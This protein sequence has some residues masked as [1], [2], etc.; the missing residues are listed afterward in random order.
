M[1]S[2]IQIF[3]NWC[4]DWNKAVLVISWFAAPALWESAQKILWLLENTWIPRYVFDKPGHFSRKDT[5][6]FSISRLKEEV[7]SSIMYLSQQWYEQIGMVS[8]SLS[9]LSVAEAAKSMKDKVTGVIYLAPVFDPKKAIANKVIHTTWI[10]IPQFTNNYWVTDFNISSDFIPL[11][12]WPNVRL[13]KEQFAQ[14]LATYGA[15]PF[16]S[17]KDIIGDA[18]TTIFRHPD[19]KIISPWLIEKLWFDTFNG[20][21]IPDDPFS[22]TI[23]IGWIADDFIA[24]IKNF[25]PGII[26]LDDELKVA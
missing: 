24:R 21:T 26:S 16:S 14:D 2:D 19:D 6:M 10:K 17:L 12:S 3:D 22:H 4:T 1:F 25:F 11:L 15:L 7:E 23:D 18:P 20:V 13:D 9:S 5:S 8:S